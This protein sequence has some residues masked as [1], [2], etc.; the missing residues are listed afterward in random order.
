M[1][2]KV[3]LELYHLKICPFNHSLLTTGSCQTNL[4]NVASF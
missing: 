4:G 2:F 1:I 3:L